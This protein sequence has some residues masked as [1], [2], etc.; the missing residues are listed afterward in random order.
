MRSLI[1][2][3]FAL[4]TACSSS[5]RLFL[6]A[7]FGGAGYEVKKDDKIPDAYR[8]KG[9]H[10]PD[11]LYKVTLRDVGYQTQLRGLRRAQEDGFDLAVIENSQGI[12]LVTYSSNRFTSTSYELGR[13][14]GFTFLIRAYKSTSTPPPNA[15][16]I[17]VLIEEINRR[18]ASPPETAPTR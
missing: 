9:I 17:T 15:K 7:D 11:T 2:L 4:L 3:C 8:A 1:L 12:A 18:A 5:E 13:F 10:N 16:P 6:Q 14:P